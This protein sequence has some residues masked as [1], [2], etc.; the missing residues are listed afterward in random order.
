MAQKKGFTL[1]EL[2][3]VIAL[4]A[5]L[6]TTVI[7]V[8][9]PAKLFQE[10]RDSQRIS[11]LGQMN[12]AMSIFLASANPVSTTYL[13]DA[14]VVDAPETCSTKCWTHGSA[15]GANCGARYAIARVTT[16]NSSQVV[17]GGGWIPVNLTVGGASAAIAAWPIDPKGNANATSFY[18]YACDNSSKT[19]EFSAKMESV[20]Y[21]GTSAESVENTDGGNNA[22]L[23][24][25]GT[26]VNAL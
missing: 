6:A 15:T 8:I 13:S 20:R 3:I 9:N 26:G 7:L 19:W 16:A 2:I 22:N 21:S 5:L 4:I 23:F 14:G 10:A 25:V 1:I 24:E 18:G 11:D 17:T 12:S